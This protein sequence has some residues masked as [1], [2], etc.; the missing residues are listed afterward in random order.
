VRRRAARPALA[1]RHRRPHRRRPRGDRRAPLHDGGDGPRLHAR[2]R[3]AVRG[4]AGLKRAALLVA[5]LAAGF[6]A[7]WVFD[8][9][10]SEQVRDWIE[11]L[12]AA[13]APVFVV[14]SAALGAALVPGPLLA[15][16]SGLLFGAVAGTFVTIASA[17]LSAVGSLVVGRHAGRAE[18]QPRFPALAE[19]SQRN[20]TLAVAAQ[21]LAPFIPDAPVSYLFGALGLNVRQIAL[22][23][24]IGSAPRAFAY[25]SIGASLD[26]P[27]SPL[28]VAGWAAVVVTGLAGL[29]IGRRW[30]EAEGRGRRRAASGRP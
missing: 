7:F 17:T 21:R 18:V 8:V 12:G 27:G 11:P 26:D 20:G 1:R 2:G 19:L 13:A 23:T 16:T 24:I 10:D 22:G 14:V 29:L 3:R 30:L 5:A 28:A 4:G 9:L 25:T 6:L 15:A